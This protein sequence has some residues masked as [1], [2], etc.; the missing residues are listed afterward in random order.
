M[1]KLE[2]YFLSY[3]FMWEDV[4]TEVEALY[5]RYCARTLPLVLFFFGL[6]LEGLLCRFIE[7]EPSFCEVCLSLA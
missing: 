4:K 7:E 6:D 1:A 5:W 2:P 3:R